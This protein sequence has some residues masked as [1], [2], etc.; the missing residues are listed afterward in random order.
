MKYVKKFGQGNSTDAVQKVT[1]S[2]DLASEIL[3][4]INISCYTE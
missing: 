1:P 4:E 3:N 2:Q